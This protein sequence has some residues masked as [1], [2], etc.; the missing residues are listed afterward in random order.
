MAYPKPRPD[1]DTAPFWEGCSAGILRFQRCSS[2]GHIRWPASYLCPKCHAVE[3]VWEPSK[4]HG[5]IYSFVVYHVAFDPAFKEDLPY[6]VAL[7]D[8]DEGPRILSNIRG[9]RPEAVEIG[10]PVELAWEDRD[11]FKLPVFRSAGPADA[12]SNA[13]AG[14]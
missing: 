7:V 9:C 6:V 1:A 5:K 3:S 14:L 12:L 2:C 10:M 13:T 4:G 8:M 11:G